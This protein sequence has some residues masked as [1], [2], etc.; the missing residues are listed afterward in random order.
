MKKREE[1]G[2]SVERRGS[3]PKGMKPYR[4]RFAMKETLQDIR[5]RRS[6]RKFQSRQIAE[7]ELNAIL[8][9][10]TWAATGHGWQSPVMVVVQDKETIAAL[11]KMNAAVLGVNSDPFYGAPTV[12]IVLADKSR[13]TC[14]EDGTLVMGNL[15]L[16]AHAVGVSSCWIHRAR[17]VFDSEEGKALL[18]KWGVE[19]DYIGVGHCVLGYAEENGEAPAKPRKENY[20]IR[21]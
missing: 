5:T 20:V 10:G 13:P 1:Y 19:G 16:A 21:V 2:V 6:C 9:A 11:S 8:E 7:E 3:L 17:E 4:R 18:R 14:R 15:M 12:V